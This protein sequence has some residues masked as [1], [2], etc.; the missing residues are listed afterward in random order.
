MEFPFDWFSVET[1]LMFFMVCVRTSVLFM[2]VCMCC[3]QDF[4]L[5]N[6]ACVR[7]FVCVCACVCVCP[8]VCVINMVYRLYNNA[9]VY[10][11]AHVRFVK[12]RV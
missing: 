1:D 3:V 9:N 4:H 8:C 7:K 5:H 10:I 2:N 12:K 11:H 6:S